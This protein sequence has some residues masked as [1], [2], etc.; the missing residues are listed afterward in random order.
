VI[1]GDRMGASP[2]GRNQFTLG[3][4]FPGVTLAQGGNAGQD[5]GG[6]RGPDTLALL[7]H[8]SRTSDQ[9]VTQ[10]GVPTSP[11]RRYR[12]PIEPASS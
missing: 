6:A 10:N 2:C 5:V 7:I 3:V 12:R 1:E 4:L 8:G 11:W 9:K